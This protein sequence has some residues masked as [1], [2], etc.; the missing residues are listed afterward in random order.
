MCDEIDDM[1]IFL[2]NITHNDYEYDDVKFMM[3]NK[4][5]DM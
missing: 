1:R 5:F 2:K 3:D 4:M